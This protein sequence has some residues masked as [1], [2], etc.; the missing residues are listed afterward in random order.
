MPAGEETIRAIDPRNAFMMDNMLRDVTIYGTAARASVTLKRQDL[1]G[2]TGTTN[3][4]MDAW[5]CG[6]QMT[7]VGCAWVG[8]DQPKTLGASGEGRGRNFIY[9]ENAKEVSSESGT[10]GVESGEAADSPPPKPD[11]SVPPSD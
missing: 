6:Y 4:Y 7:V 11:L 8:F 5:F 1:A 9:A 2:K 3:E 10:E